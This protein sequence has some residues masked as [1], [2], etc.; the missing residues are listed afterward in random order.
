VENGEFTTVTLTQVKDMGRVVLHLFRKLNAYVEVL[1]TQYM[2]DTNFCN[3]V[4][5]VP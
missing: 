1:S 5:N 4:N 3:P 2:W